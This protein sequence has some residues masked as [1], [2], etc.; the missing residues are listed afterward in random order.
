MKSAISAALLGRR[1]AVIAI[2]VPSGAVLAMVSV[3][4]FDP[5]TL[6]QA[7]D[8]LLKDP[9]APLLNRVTQGLYQPGGSLETV[10]LAAMLTDKADLNVP[11][12]GPA[13][14]L[15]IHGLTVQS[16]R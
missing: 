15:Q 8:V 12:P 9:A 2:D 4:T 7:Y 11:V 14:P 13:P 1:G 6:D 5:N 10:I 16:T 3:P